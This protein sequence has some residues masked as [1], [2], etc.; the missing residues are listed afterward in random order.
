MAS[1]LTRKKLEIYNYL[2]QGIA[3]QTT[4]PKSGE[5]RETEGRNGI[6]AFDYLGQKFLKV[7]GDSKMSH[8]LVIFN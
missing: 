2:T 7:I 1:T 3:G 8:R 4:N 5:K 6:Q